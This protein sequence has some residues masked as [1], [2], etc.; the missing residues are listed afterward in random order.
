MSHSEVI[1][2]VN[3]I[4]SDEDTPLSASSKLDVALKKVDIG[5]KK[6]KKSQKVKVGTKIIQ[7]NEEVVNG[8]EVFGI[9]LHQGTSSSNPA[10]LAPLVWRLIQQ[11]QKTQ[12]H[13]Q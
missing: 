11:L 2:S 9:V 5:S 3:L 4:S 12:A 8:A 10:V 7:V 6:M 13:S 1:E